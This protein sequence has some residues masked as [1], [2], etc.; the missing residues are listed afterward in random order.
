MWLRALPRLQFLNVVE[1]FPGSLK[2]LSSS[3]TSLEG[4]RALV[5]LSIFP[6]PPTTHYVVTAAPERDFEPGFTVN[7]A[8]LGTSERTS[9]GTSLG[10]ARYL[11]SFWCQ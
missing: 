6:L 9:T 2:P 11:A 3:T 5:E 1:E 7:G 4:G 10:S 8:R